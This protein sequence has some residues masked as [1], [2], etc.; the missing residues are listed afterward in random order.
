MIALLESMT[1][2]VFLTYTL[3]YTL[4]KLP[5]FTVYEHP[6]SCGSLCVLL[7][8]GVRT[9]LENECL[10]LPQTVNQFKH[11]CRNI[12]L[13]IFWRTDR[14]RSVDVL[15]FVF[16]CSVA[17]MSA[18]TCKEFLLFSVSITCLCLQIHFI[19]T[20]SNNPMKSQ[21]LKLS[22]EDAA[23]SAV[24]VHHGNSNFTAQQHGYFLL[25][26]T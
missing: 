6:P 23:K 17:V 4:N 26:K 20:M 11:A 10:C 7:R 24:Y 25:G 22:C 1:L 5:L 16:R 2:P 15:F 21:M 9:R 18:S 14:R 13:I 12:H 3:I 19:S 8:S